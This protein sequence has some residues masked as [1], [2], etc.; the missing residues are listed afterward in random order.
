MRVI[1]SAIY[2]VSR[3]IYSQYCWCVYDGGRNIHDPRLAEGGS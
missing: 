1:I 2:I 3:L